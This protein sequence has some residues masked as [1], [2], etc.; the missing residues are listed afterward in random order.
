MR[1]L[2][3]LP[4][5]DEDLLFDSE[6]AIRSISHPCGAGGV[7]GRADADEPALGVPDEQHGLPLQQRGGG[8]GRLH[9][10]EPGHGADD[11][12]DGL[13]AL[14][15]QGVRG[16]PVADGVHAGVG[17][18]GSDPCDTVAVIRFAEI[19]IYYAA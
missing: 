11:A 9:Q 12:V 10:G 6:T 16:R 7:R 4:H 13:A 17:A 5:R 15:A 1:Q 8:V 19:M 14:L 2:I 18:P 3:N